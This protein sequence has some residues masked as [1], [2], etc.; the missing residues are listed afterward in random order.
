MKFFMHS[1]VARYSKD[2]NRLEHEYGLAAIGFYWKVVEMILFSEGECNLYSLLA[3]RS[4]PLRFPQCEQILKNSKLFIYDAVRNVVRINM[5]SDVGFDAPDSDL[6]KLAEAGTGARTQARTEARTEARREAPV[7]AGPITPCA[8]NTTLDT[9]TEGASQ[10]VEQDIE[11]ERALMQ[12]L[13]SRCPSLLE[14]EKPL[15]LE[16]YKVLR[17]R[18]GP[19]E[20]EQVLIDMDN[21]PKVGRLR[22]CFVTAD[23]W[24]RVRS[25]ASQVNR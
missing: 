7:H 21:D 20:I 23:K 15:T 18:Y 12:F 25:G 4:Q 3:L 11:M 24:L 16:Q 10:R 9:E 2:L 8:D 13:S 14:M 5:E 19:E 1:T 22:G 17:Q 6:D